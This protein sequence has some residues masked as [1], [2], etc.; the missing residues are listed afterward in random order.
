MSLANPSDFQGI[1][2][3]CFDNT[4]NALRVTSAAESQFYGPEGIALIAGARTLVVT[5]DVPRLALV[6]AATTTFGTSFL[7][8]NYWTAADFGFFYTSSAT[9]AG[10]YRWRIAVK[11]SALFIDNITEAFLV[12]NSVTLDAPDQGIVTQEIQPVDNLNASP[13][14]F[15]T[16]FTCIVSRIGGDAA[17]TCT[18]TAELIGIYARRNA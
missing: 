15:G 11:K 8:P 1:L 10:N 3:R 5:N 12:D 2:Q 17:D 18:A 14:V 4:N 7:L 6:D 13:D 9:A 16:L